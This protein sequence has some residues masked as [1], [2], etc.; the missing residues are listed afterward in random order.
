[1]RGGVPFWPEECSRKLL[2]ACVKHC[3]LPM[4]I[5]QWPT[6]HRPVLHEYSSSIYRT[7][8]RRGENVVSKNELEGPSEKEKWSGRLD[9]NQRPHAPQACA[10]PG[11]AT[12]RLCFVARV[13]R[14][15]RLYADGQKN[16]RL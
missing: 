10:L 5:L 7:P 11:C 16:P 8:T 12:S 14:R 4:A 2:P 9:L 6:R 1:M 15:G 3:G 13:F